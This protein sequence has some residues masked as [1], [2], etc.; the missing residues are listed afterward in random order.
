MRSKIV[1]LSVSFQRTRFSCTCLVLALLLFTAHAQVEP[2][3]F[4]LIIPI[5]LFILFILFVLPLIFM[6]LLGVGLLGLGGNGLVGNGLV[7]NGL[8]AIGTTGLGTLGTNQA[9]P[10]VIFNPALGSNVI[11][12][13]R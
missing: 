9:Q 6:P 3:D 8:G 4:V 5:I 11:P 2:E 7:G 13:G 12:N 1:W 10:V